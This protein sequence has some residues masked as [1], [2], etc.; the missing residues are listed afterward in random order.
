MNSPN[1]IYFYFNVCLM[2]LLLICP[3]KPTDLVQ[4]RQHW[5]YKDLQ[6]HSVLC[7]HIS[8]SHI[9]CFVVCLRG[10]KW[11]SL[12]ILIECQFDSACHVCRWCCCDPSESY[13][14]KQPITERRRIITSWGSLDLNQEKNQCHSASGLSCD[15]TSIWSKKALQI[16]HKHESLKLGQMQPKE[17]CVWMCVW[18][19][20]CVVCWA[21]T[22]GVCGTSTR[23]FYNV[24]SIFS[25]HHSHTWADLMHHN[26][27]DSSVCNIWSDFIPERNQIFIV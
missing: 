2:E 3:F 12:G 13:C 8:M 20:R 14:V 1:V 27:T 21:V 5:H 10:K 19:E 23:D 17:E 15:I 25:K 11:F 6:K 18:S 24:R 4:K 9:C 26:I 7:T 16:S 22:A